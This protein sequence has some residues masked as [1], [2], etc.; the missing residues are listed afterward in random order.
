LSLFRKDLG[1]Q[2]GLV[3]DRQNAMLQSIGILVAFASI[4]FLQLLAM[5]PVF[6]GYGFFF[7]ASIESVLFCCIIGVLMILQTSRFA[8]SAG[9]AI[10]EEVI[11]Y[12]SDEINNLEER[13]TRGL[14][15]AYRTVYKNNTR[16]MIIIKYMVALLLIGIITMF[17]GWCLG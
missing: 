2:L 1:R 7:V 8:L 17:A 16:L 11:L 15:G 4:L 9:M 14:I 5:D 3:S 10:E 6:E 13:I 12:N